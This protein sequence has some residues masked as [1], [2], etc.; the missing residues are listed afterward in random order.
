MRHN[1]AVWRVGQL[2]LRAARVMRGCRLG[3]H[4]GVALQLRRLLRSLSHIVVK[5]ELLLGDYRVLGVAPHTFPV[6]AAC[7]L[8]LQRFLQPT[9]PGVSSRGLLGNGWRLIIRFVSRLV[10]GGPSRL[11]LGNDLRD[12]PENTLALFHGNL[13]LYHVLGGQVSLLH[14]ELLRLHLD[15]FAGAGLLQDVHK[16]VHTIYIIRPQHVRLVLLD[17]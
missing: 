13:D 3:R 9:I 1:R 5:H 11:L 4:R 7:V 10:C 2:L 6:F 17:L 14:Y 8:P 12:V 15:L 16:L